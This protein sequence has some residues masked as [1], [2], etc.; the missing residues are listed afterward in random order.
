MSR[1]RLTPTRSRAG[2]RFVLVNRHAAR[3]VSLMVQGVLSEGRHRVKHNAQDCERREAR[4]EKERQEVLGES[5]VTE[6]PSYGRRQTMLLSEVTVAGSPE[7]RC[8]WCLGKRRA[9]R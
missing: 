8:D 3:R 5:H 6:V 2:S 9:D 4:R 1:V 7:E